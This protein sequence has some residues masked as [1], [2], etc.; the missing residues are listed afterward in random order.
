MFLEMLESLFHLH[1]TLQIHFYLGLLQSN[2]EKI[3]FQTIGQNVFLYEN[4][5]MHGN[6]YK[7]YVV[8]V[9][10]AAIIIVVIL[11]IIIFI[12]IMLIIIS[13]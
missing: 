7:I 5:N 1:Y 3:T 9:A 6:F 4:R 12:F 10:A 11:T 8:V 2:K 13:G